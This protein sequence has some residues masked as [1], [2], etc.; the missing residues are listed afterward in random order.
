MK[1]AG[2]ILLMIIGALTLSGCS[3]ARQLENQAYVIAM[4]IDV[5][6]GGDI[7]LS[8]QLPKISGGQQDSGGANSSY[9]PVSVR[10]GTFDHALEEL[11][12]SV[13]RD[14]NLSQLEL[15]V[16]SQDA[17]FS[18]DFAG[19]IEKLA[20]TQ[21]IY[22]AAS[23]IICEGHA[24]EFI[25]ALKPGLGSRLSADIL[26]RLDHCRGLGILP[27]CS[28][29]EVF[30]RSNAP[31]SDPMAGYVTLETASDSGGDTAEP[32][33]SASS[34]SQSSSKESKEAVI[35]FGGA[36][37]LSG[38][39]CKALLSAEEVM[40]VNLLQGRLNS[41]RWS[42][43]GASIALQNIGAPQIMVDTSASPAKISILLRLS[44]EEQ[45]GLPELDVIR[46]QLSSDIMQLIEKMQ[47]L[48][49][50]PFGIAESAAAS[51]LTL[52]DWQSYGWKARWKD[53]QT[54]IKLQLS[55][56]GT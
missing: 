3:A 9:V 28:L 19:L 26:A 48:Q 14:M 7:E 21:N 15:I 22:T 5:S 30:Y 38:G 49:L 34:G 50:E 47:R 51:F 32:A 46:R 13:P 31:Y 24:G 12:R 36:A 8:V 52:Q 20:G 29:A 45:S 17:A 42:C 39:I 53:A 37:V 55:A 16:L 35:R 4:G 1:K 40:L 44:I 18:K 23:V 43:G 56:F 6:T 33:S 25:R 11:N 41:F 2:L 10:A 54:E 27:E